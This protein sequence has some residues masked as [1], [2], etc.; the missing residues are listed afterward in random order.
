LPA[1][2]FVDKNRLFEYISH[3]V[4]LGSVRGVPHSFFFTLLSR[5]WFNDI[6]RQSLHDANGV[7][8]ALVEYSLFKLGRVKETRD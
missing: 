6:A 5:H 7:E 4:E 2:V 8:L 3:L 1:L